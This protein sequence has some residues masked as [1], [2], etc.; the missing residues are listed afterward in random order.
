MSDTFIDCPGLKPTPAGLAKW[1]AIVPSATV[2]PLLSVVSNLGIAG[3]LLLEWG[4]VFLRPG[5]LAIVEPARDGGLHHLEI[6]RDV[7]V[8]GREQ[9]VVPDVHDL[10]VAVV[11]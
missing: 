5:D 4:R 10:V 8:A 2:S 3:F 9:A 6:R 11:A 1:N 7:E